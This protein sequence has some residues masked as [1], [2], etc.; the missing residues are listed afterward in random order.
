MLWKDILNIDNRKRVIPFYRYVG[1][2]LYETEQDQYLN[3]I[4]VKLKERQL[5]III[6]QDIQFSYFVN[7]AAFLE[8]KKN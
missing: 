2:S 3:L 5:N 8:I 7:K 1:H 4:F 6:S